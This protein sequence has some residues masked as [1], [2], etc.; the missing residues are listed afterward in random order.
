MSTYTT[1]VSGWTRRTAALAAIAMLSAV[2]CKSP[3]D[4]LQV[5]DPDIINPANVASAAG[6]DAVRLGALARLNTATTGGTADGI[7]LLGG[8]FADDMDAEKPHVIL[9]EEELEETFIVADD[10]TAGIVGVCGASGDIG[11]A[12]GLER[13]LGV[14]GHRT[15]GYGIDAVG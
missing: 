3:D 9:G 2:G 1:F 15:F 12:L 11:D 14:A 4:F 10:P 7:F 13:L 8:L 6:A 5:T